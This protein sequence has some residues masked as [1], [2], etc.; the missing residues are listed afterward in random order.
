MDITPASLKPSGMPESMTTSLS[1]KELT[2][3]GWCSTG[4]CRLSA[5]GHASRSF[6]SSDTNCI[7][8]QADAALVQD[9]TLRCRTRLKY[10]EYFA[11]DIPRGQL[12]LSNCEITSDSLACVAIH[13][14]TANPVIQNCKIH[15]GKEG[16]V[17]VYESG[18]GTLEDCD[19]FANAV[20]G[21]QI[22]EGGDPVI[23][24]C[25]I[26]S[27]QEA[28]VLVE[29]NGQGVLEDCDIFANA[30]AGVEIRDAGN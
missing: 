4:M 23:H 12:T 22:S 30:L 19:I 11:I 27:Q 6:L 24:G 8:M 21:V 10:K 5:M 28:G 2:W 9:L 18:Q 7:L 3:K 29:Q 17:I 13:G 26:H 15:G 14:L 20:L 25:K 16:G 1:G